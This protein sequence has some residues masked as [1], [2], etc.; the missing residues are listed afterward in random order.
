MPAGAS[1]RNF[2]RS[3][4]SQALDRLNADPA[5]SRVSNAGLTMSDLQALLWYPEKRLYDSSKAPEG[6]QS[7]GYADDEAPDYAN[8]ARKLVEARKGSPSGGR[9]GSARTAG[10]GGRGATSPDA[11]LSQSISGGILRTPTQREFDF[12][13]TL[14]TDQ[15]FKSQTKLANVP[16][17]V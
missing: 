5:V 12:G 8:A 16:F 13:R 6:E 11:R 4:F 14:P 7:R 9:L 17:E 15:E 3:V 1:E 2:I 10:D